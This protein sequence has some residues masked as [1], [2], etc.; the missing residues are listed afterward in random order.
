[1]TMEQPDYD[2]YLEGAREDAFAE[3]VLE[4]REESEP[5]DVTENYDPSNPDFIAWS[6]SM[7]N[8]LNEGG[9]WGVPRSGLI[10]TK[11]D[12]GLVLVSQMP[13]IDGMDVTPEQLAEQQETEF[14]SIREHFA[15]A[16]IDVTKESV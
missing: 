7:Y 15:A 14:D 10:F 8:S 5:E 2:K 9:M 13:H 11:R 6:R 16:G 4:A 12:G 3:A 1:M